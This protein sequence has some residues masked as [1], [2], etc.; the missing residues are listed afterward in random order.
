MQAV[1]LAA[2]ESSRFWPLNNKNKCLF[3][4]MG[5]PLIS[6]VVKGLEKAGIKNIV[7]VQGPQ[8]EVEK[9]L[10]KEDFG[11][12]IKYA[13]LPEAK[14]MG[15]ALSVARGFLEESFFVVGGERI[16]AG[17]FVSEILEKKKNDKA[18]AVILG[19]RTNHPSVYGI[20]DLEGE[21]VKSIIEKPAEGRELSDIKAVSLYLLSKDFLGYYDKAEKGIYDF[22]SALNLYAKEKKLTALITEKHISTLKYPWH[23]FGSL[24]YLMDNFLKSGKGKNVRIGKNVLIEGNV[25]I[26]NGA[27]IFDGA[28]IKGPVF[29]GDNSVVGTNSLI[30]D[31]SSL[32]KDSVVGSLAEVARSVFQKGAHAHSGFLGDSVLGEECRIGAGTVMANLRIDR[33]EVK[34]R[35]K[36]EKIK[37]GLNSLGAIIGEKTKVGINCS[38]MPGVLIGS[39]CVIGPSSAVF[40]NIEDGKTFY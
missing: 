15:S 7:V 38:F 24:K 29:I 34:S 3:E 9:E 16:G 28:V 11:A 17:D 39:N 8:K 5:R 23:L 20:L 10:A 30:R 12:D 22:E 19:A 36:G 25:S 33:G 32:E 21:R 26:G 27:R 14:G 6:W 2:G 37:T 13:V 35:I 18:D 40:G 4:L 31:Y 1:I